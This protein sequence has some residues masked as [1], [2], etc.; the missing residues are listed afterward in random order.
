MEF[1]QTTTWSASGD[2]V[3][4]KKDISSEKESSFKYKIESSVVNIYPDITYQTID[5]FGGAMTDTSA[6]LLSTLTPE[7]RHEA[8]S[9]YFGPN[10]DNYNFIRVPIDSC[11]YSLEEYQAVDDP[12]SD[13]ELK[14][15]SMSRNFKYIL[16][17][18]KEAISLSTRKISVL[19]S[20]WSP[21]AQWKE[22][23][24]IPALNDPSVYMF[25]ANTTKSDISTSGRCFGGYLK[26]EYYASWARY[27]VMVVLSYLHEGIPVTMLTIQ[28]EPSAVTNWDSCIWSA[29]EEKDFLQNYLY[30]EFQKNRLDDKVDIF[31]WDHNKERVVERAIRT[32]TPE[33]E[34]MVKGIAFHWYS[35]DHFESIKILHD[36]FPDKILMLSECCEY[37]TPMWKGLNTSGL[38]Q[39]TPHTLE[40]LEAKHY[41]HDIIGNLNAGMNRWID[42]N[43]FVDKDGGPRHVPGGFE[44]TSIINDDGTTRYKLSYHYVRAIASNIQP[45]A[46]RIAYS[47]YTD[48]FEM[49]SV[50]NPDN[51]ITAVFLNR[52][53]E[54]KAAYVRIS[55]EVIKL[56]IPADTLSV[57]KSR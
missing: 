6:Y 20:P 47:K 34:H 45:G 28:N 22:N 3:I 24:N 21:P 19:L 10:G 30:P 2:P 16:P 40:L 57:L 5:G 46:V 12:I 9:M 55:G 31:I 29:D 54:D 48:D 8:L 7:K 41:A 53:H 11:D 56:S 4:I 17:A 39:I 51:T 15:F 25:G 52:E 1:I 32:I 49:T 14:T 35:G 18:L 38:I 50:L 37:N 13:P 33:T 44:G 23:V 43:L 26:H 42:W 36:R 27:L